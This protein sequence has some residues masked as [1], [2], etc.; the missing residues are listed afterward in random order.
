MNAHNIRPHRGN[1]V[2]VALGVGPDDRAPRRRDDARHR[3]QPGD[4]RRMRPMTRSAGL[5]GKAET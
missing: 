5:V 3:W 1:D 2:G 4:V